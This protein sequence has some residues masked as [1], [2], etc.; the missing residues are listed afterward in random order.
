MFRTGD[1]T[2]RA[3][4]QGESLREAERKRKE[5]E[6]KL[7]KNG[8]PTYRLSWAEQEEAKKVRRCIARPPH[9]RSFG[10]QMAF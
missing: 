1:Q 4:T 6:D 2:P 10:L 9:R 5:K 7:L 8:A 3:K